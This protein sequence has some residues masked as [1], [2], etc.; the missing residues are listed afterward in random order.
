MGTRRFYTLA[1]LEDIINDPY[2]LDDDEDNGI[3]I[4][5][6]PPDNVDDVSDVEEI[7]KDI[8]EDTCPKDF[9]GKLKIHSAAINTESLSPLDV[10]PDETPYNTQNEI[11]Q[12]RQMKTEARKLKPNLDWRKCRSDFIKNFWDNTDIVQA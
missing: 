1:E 7:D 12:K 3:Y 8:L 2:F 6:L 5:E 9:P 4:V 10:T 11:T